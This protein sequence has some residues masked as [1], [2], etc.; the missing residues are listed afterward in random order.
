MWASTGAGTRAT[1][2]LLIVSLSVRLPAAQ[3][4]SAVSTIAVLSSNL[5]PYQQAFDVF[6]ERLGEP[7]IPSVLPHQEPHMTPEVQTVV[8]FGGKATIWRYG[9]RVKIV[10]CMAPGIDE[11]ALEDPLAVIRV[12]SIP[13][14]EALVGLLRTLQPTA[15]RLAVLSSGDLYQ[16]Y[17]GLLKTHAV[18]LGIQVKAL[19]VNSSA[20]PETLRGL[21]NQ[22][23][24]LWIPPD[25]Y[26]LNAQNFEVIEEF[27][28]ANRIPLYV[29]LA[30]LVERG[31][32][33]AIAPSF[34]MVGETAANVVLQL[35][36]GQNVPRDI[37]PPRS[38][39][40][41]SRSK[42]AKVGIILTDEQAKQATTVLP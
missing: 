42:L 22:T 12:R 1:V 31:A 33:V 13:R 27:A 7:L 38:E 25:P 29:P 37:Y 14:A 5:L 10:S 19:R 26:F 9:R 11:T 18:T 24:A 30:G 39:I 17:E 36:Q 20:L 35:R 16:D 23:D 41:L 34:A 28:E 32:A 6:K 3:P 40:T 4:T 8:A 15:T 2:A 21:L